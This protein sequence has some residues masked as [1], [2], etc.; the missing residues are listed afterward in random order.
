MAQPYKTCPK[1]QEGTNTRICSQHSERYR[2]DSYQVNMKI[3]P[4]NWNFFNILSVY[5]LWIKNA[6]LSWGVVQELEP[7]DLVKRVRYCKWVLE[8]VSKV[9]STHFYSLQQAKPCSI[10]QDMSILKIRSIGLHAIPLVSHQKPLHDLKIGVL[11]AVSGRRI[12]GPSFF[13]KTVNTNVYLQ[14]YKEFTK[15]L[16]QVKISHDYFQ[17]DGAT[18]HTTDRSLAHIHNGFTVVRTISR[19]LATQ[20]ERPISLWL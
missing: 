14:I 9:S 20:I 15:H 18:C 13:E 11:C 12:I 19:V 3:S 6:R 2:K 7:V 1:H 8:N 10:Y 17:Q 4:T 16:T 5:I